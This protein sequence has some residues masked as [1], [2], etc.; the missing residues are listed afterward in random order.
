MIDS[1]MA[2]EDASFTFRATQIFVAVVE[3]GSVTRAAHRLGMSPS[4]V[5]QQ[6]SSLEASLGAKLL[7]RTARKFELTSAGVLFLDPAKKLIDDVGAAKARLLMASESPPMALRIASFEELDATVTAAWL[8]KLKERFPNLALTLTSG[9][10]HE[11]HDALE[12]RAID[13]MVAVDTVAKTEW[14]E[15]HPILRD[16]FILVASKDLPQ[17]P[18][19]LDVFSDLPFVRYTSDLQIGR[20]IEAQLRR[21]GRAPSRGFEFTT[22]Q[23]LFSMTA[24]LGGWSISTALAFVGTPLAKERL[25]AFKLPFPR[26]SR[27]IALHCRAGALDDLPKECA[28]ELRTT[29]QTQV[30]DKIGQTLPFLTDEMSI[31]R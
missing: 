25:N 18:L 6:L 3:A 17:H 7:E 19:D 30:L 28:E 4:S 14:I 2:N 10:S 24:E 8:L 29:L 26:F 23:A 15:T 20:Q 9:A 16:P 13:L 1:D 12:T 31:I 22:N 27:R 5:S 21:L 11:N